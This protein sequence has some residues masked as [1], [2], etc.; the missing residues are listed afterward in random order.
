MRWKDNSTGFERAHNCDAKAS[1]AIHGAGWHVTQYDDLNQ[2]VKAFNRQW[3]K[4]IR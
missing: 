4:S 1:K 3:Q 2:I